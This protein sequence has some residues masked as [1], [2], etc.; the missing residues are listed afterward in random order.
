MLF[1][2]FGSMRS[3]IAFVDP[4]RRQNSLNHWLA[5]RS[6]RLEAGSSTC[7]TASA[8]IASDFVASSFIRE[9]R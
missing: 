9:P 8:V 6:W 5:A 3:E 2:Q 1:V 7:T 4:K